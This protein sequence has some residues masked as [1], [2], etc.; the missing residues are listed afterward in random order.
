MY[1]KSVKDLFIGYTFTNF[2]NYLQTMQNGDDSFHL[3]A[4]KSSLATT[5][6]EKI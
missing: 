5:I 2:K 4:L 1:S 3:K 6:N